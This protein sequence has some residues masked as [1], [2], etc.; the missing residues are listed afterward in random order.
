M[1]ATNDPSSSSSADKAICNANS[2]RAEQIKVIN[3]YKVHVSGSWNYIV[4]LSVAS[5]P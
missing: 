2:V 1:L 5:W 4:K 3:K